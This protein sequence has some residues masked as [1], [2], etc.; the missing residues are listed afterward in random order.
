[1]VNHPCHFLTPWLLF[2]TTNN[3]PIFF[4][5]DIWPFQP[6]A[7]MASPSLTF[8]QHYNSPKWLIFCM[9][10]VYLDSL[11]TW[12]LSPTIL[13]P[14]DTLA[15]S[16]NTLSCTFA[17]LK[18]VT[19]NF[20]QTILS[21]SANALLTNVLLSKCPTEPMSYSPNVLLSQCPT[22]E[23]SYLILYTQVC[24]TVISPS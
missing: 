2:E 18:N 21:Y 5:I 10:N 14:Y 9:S 17:L 1:M 8:V 24:P 11:S 12:H 22:Q 19:F 3:Q 15:F 4:P 16:N 7:N 23:L 13:M 6:L 20:F